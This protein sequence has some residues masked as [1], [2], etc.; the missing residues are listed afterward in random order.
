M[1]D[2]PTT[3]CRRRERELFSMPRFNPA[4]DLE[5]S[6]D[7]TLGVEAVI[8]TFFKNRRIYK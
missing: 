8:A 7:R 3:R 5:R 4:S 2:H 6:K 1:L